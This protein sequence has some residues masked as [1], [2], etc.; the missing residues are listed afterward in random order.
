M[1]V[2]GADGQYSDVMATGIKRE[3]KGGT[4]ELP[5]LPMPQAPGP[6]LLYLFFA[7]ANG[8]GYTGSVC[9]DMGSRDF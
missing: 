3:A 4:F 1:A 9:F 5:A 2:S 7:S 6:V 8:K